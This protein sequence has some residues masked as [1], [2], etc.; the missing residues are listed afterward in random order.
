[1]GSDF[2]PGRYW[3]YSLSR[4]W[5][6]CLRRVFYLVYG[7]W[8]GWNPSNGELPRKLY[9]YK[10]ASTIEQFTGT[11]VHDAVRKTLKAVRNGFELPDDAKMVDR[12]E[13]I[14]RDGL[15]YSAA[16]HWR[17][18]RHPG[19]ATLILVNHLVGDDLSDGLVDNM[20][21]RARLCMEVFLDRFL[22]E[23][24]EID[25]DHWTTIDSLDAVR[26]NDYDVFAAADFRIDE[27]APRHRQIIDWKSG[28]GTDTAQLFTYTLTT[29]LA[30]LKQGRPS[31]I[32]N[33]IGR[34]ISLLT[35]DEE[36]IGPTHEDLE[37]TRDRVCKSINEMKSLNDAGVRRDELAFPKTIYK[38]IC[39]YCKLQAYCD[40]RQ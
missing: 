24:L 2:T 37:E 4:D 39:K 36:R 28:R 40:T 9:Q 12:I 31:R 32:G 18:V 33:T 8:G 30:D 35:G 15:E 23:F 5:E 6:E 10:K 34:S 13:A 11:A 7:S 22:P 26:L 29:E 27:P 19:R 38:G 25:T 1:M 17:E 3:S 16:K 20:V 21:E 14:I